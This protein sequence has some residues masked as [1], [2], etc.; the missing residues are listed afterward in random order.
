MAQTILMA[1][2]RSFYASVEMAINPELRGRPIA[3]CGD[4]ERRSGICL[5]ANPEAKRRGVKTAMAC[6]QVLQACPETVI[7]RPHMQTYLDFSLRIRDIAQSFTPN[8]EVFSVDEMW[9]DVSG[10][11]SL[12]G[13][14]WDIARKFRERVR[15]EVGV[16]SCVAISYN[17]F[18]SKMCLDHEAK[19]SREQIAEWRPKDVRRKMWPM[20]IENMYMVASRMMRNFQHLGIFTI[21]DLARYPLERLKRQFGPIMGQVY[22][23]LAHG[24]DDSPISP[25]TLNEE[26][27]GIS[28]GA[29]LPQDYRDRK[30]IAIVIRELTDE[31]CRRAR[32]K[33]KAGRTVS[34]GVRHFD[35]S[36]GFHRSASMAHFSNLA[37]D[38]MATALMLFD[39]HWNGQPVR[40]VSVGLSNLSA[41][42]LQLDLFQDKSKQRALA[43]TV[44]ALK[45][46]YGPTA[47]MRAV[48]LM[49][50]GLAADR[51]A[52]IG[53]HYR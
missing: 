21:G 31:V 48:S 11:E 17:K 41:D 24:R 40:A 32:A 42:V 51:G 16:E 23:E 18:M 44:D 13:S 4:P 26:M 30:S 9:L 20:P 36:S 52:K 15:K 43:N 49:P 34:L 14:P 28:H 38:V 2:M 35:L 6:W 45:N 33:A 46:R 8:V 3:V 50:A 7:V 22:H 37:E 29:T 5:A 47:V 19:K 25:Y 53:G 12:F 27:K 39:Q 1:D 10:C